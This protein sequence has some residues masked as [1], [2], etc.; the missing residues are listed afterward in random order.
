MLT[1]KTWVMTKKG[2]DFEIDLPAVR[3]VCPRCEGS[4]SHVNPSVDGNGLSAEDLDDDDFRESY[5]QG[6][7]DVQCEECKG[8][9]VVLR[10]DWDKLTDKMKDRVQRQQRQESYDRQEAEG[11][12]RWGA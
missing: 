8:Q 7:Y 6:H 5:M 12:R 2:N 1:I 10:L 3:V 9:N 11:E 4:G